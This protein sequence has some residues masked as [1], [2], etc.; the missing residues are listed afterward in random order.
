MK[1]ITRTRSTRRRGAGRNRR[2][3]LVKTTPS[4]WVV[5][6]SSSPFPIAD[7]GGLV[8]DVLAIGEVQ[9]QFAFI[10][11]GTQVLEIV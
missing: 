5:H 3:A 7:Q 9:N 8:S 11:R 1:S 2:G 10:T 4:V 6:G